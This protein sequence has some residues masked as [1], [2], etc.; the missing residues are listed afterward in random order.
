MQLPVV[1]PIGDHGCSRLKE[2]ALI[3][4]DQRLYKQAKDSP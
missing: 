3:Y 4:D 1:S 2:A